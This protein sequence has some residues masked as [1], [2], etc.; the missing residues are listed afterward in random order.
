MKSDLKPLG[1]RRRR[2]GQIYIPRT[3]GNLEDLAFYRKSQ[4]LRQHI[5][6]AGPPGTGKTAGSEAAFDG[7][8][9]NEEVD[10]NSKLGLY[11]IVG[12]A[13][14]TT[15]DFVGGYVPDPETK[16]YTWHNGPLINSILDNVPL[17]VDEIG[18]IDPK[19][20]SIL[21]PLMDGRN[22][23]EVTQNPSL[24]PIHVSK[25]PG[26][27]VIA[28]YNPDVPDVYM[29]EALV[30]RFTH[31]ILVEANWDLAKQLGVLEAIVDI[32]E[33]L[34]LKRKKGEIAYSL[35]MRALLDFKSI[36]K[37][38]GLDFAI[39]DTIS[40]MPEDDQS[41]LISALQSHAMF[42][43]KSDIMAPLSLGGVYEDYP[44]GNSH[45]E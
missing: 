45:F 3:V 5:L 17:L 4:E 23:L 21:Y 25:E 9:P 24:P 2:N 14:T 30:D 19:V 18:L 26:W 12:S 1:A 15:D 11:T 40:K 35:Q 34:N 16:A 42:K 31:R 20:I 44:E 22:I 6:L 27:F 36:E 43:S 37:E 39:Q 41:A 38:F 7:V 33:N 28:A 10:P 13:G 32:A 29:S 8:A